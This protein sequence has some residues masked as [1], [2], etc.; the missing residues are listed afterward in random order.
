MSLSDDELD[1]LIG[2]VP[3]PSELGTRSVK[4]FEQIVDR[5]VPR[6]LHFTA[7]DLYDEYVANDDSSMIEESLALLHEALAALTLPLDARNEQKAGIL[8]DIASALLLRFDRHGDPAD[9]LNSIRMNC[10]AIGA[11][12]LYSEVHICILDGFRDAIDRLHELKERTEVDLAVEFFRSPGIIHPDFALDP[13]FVHICGL[14]LYAHFQLLKFLAI[15]DLHG[16]IL[17]FRQAIDGFGKVKVKARKGYLEC[18]RSLGCA[19]L[20]CFDQTGDEDHLKDLLESIMIHRQV[21]AS[22]RNKKGLDEWAL[23]QSTLALSLQRVS[24]P[25]DKPH[26]RHRY[27][28]RPR[29]L[30]LV[31]DDPID[32]AIGLH[33]A[34]RENLPRED[35]NSPE[36]I[37]IH[38]IAVFTKFQLRSNP[39]DLLASTTL[40]K[41]AIGP[42]QVHSIDSTK[43]KELYSRACHYLALAIQE[44][45]PP[46]LEGEIGSTTRKL[47]ESIAYFEIAAIQDNVRLNNLAKALF[48][49]YRLCND[50][51][52]VDKAV[53]AFIEALDDTTEAPRTRLQWAGHWVDFLYNNTAISELMDQDLRDKFLKYCFDAVALLRDVASFDQTIN[54]RLET[55]KASSTLAHRASVLAIALGNARCGIEI[56]EGGR[57]I[58]WS[59]ALRLR[60][61]STDPTMQGV[62]EELRHFMHWD[63]FIPKTR[64]T[65]ESEKLGRRR[66]VAD[67]EADLD[68]RLPM[69]FDTYSQLSKCCKNGAVVILV[70]GLCESYAVLLRHQEEEPEVLTLPKM[71]AV[72]LR[73]RS[74]A[75]DRSDGDDEEIERHGKKRNPAPQGYEAALSTLWHDIVRPIIWRL[76]YKKSDLRNRPRIWWCPSGLF[77][78]LPLHAAGIYSG[79]YQDCLSDHAISSYTTSLSG[80]TRAQ[81]R[82]TR[83][84]ENEKVLVVAEPDPPAFFKLSKIENVVKEVEIIKGL[85][86]EQ[87]FVHI[88]EAPIAHTQP[89]APS[90]RPTV[91]PYL[92][93]VS[94]AFEGNL[95]AHIVHFSCHAKQDQESP[96]FSHFFI[97][98]TRLTVGRLMEMEFPNARFA[99]LSACQTATGDRVQ[100]EESI[101]LASVMSFVGFPS[102]IGTMWPM[103]DGDGP[104]VTEKV[105]RALF[106]NGCL[107][108]NADL[109][110]IALDDAVRQM[111]AQKIPAR[112][113]APY[114]HI[115]G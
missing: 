104:F 110:P 77:T 20:D 59:Q 94:T 53:L 16:C 90:S 25:M 33:V 60:D 9:L 100:S 101:H 28:N 45:L 31:G 58:F 107:D 38:G 35:E 86:P 42:L 64:N 8:D 115:G 3:K 102:I 78:S 29:S 36:Y 67:F 27:R 6:M 32:E 10:E 30:D 109:I 83:P 106:K 19:L 79:N 2:R 73:G 12:I 74:S 48:Y 91:T 81:E 13:V 47:D 72:Y 82:L 46:H 57:A 23:H 51:A 65:E 1:G 75:F 37:L 84:F 63:P 5:G 34:I 69:A 41:E 14:A 89:A 17:L 87:S 4:G 7:L 21:L 49:K 92:S 52:T 54:N 88:S 85:V 39:E 50:H 44:S 24:F 61:A 93:Q 68:E 55:L 56:L 97:M 111:R 103:N 114:I 113:W 99:F 80:L 62:A 40:L 71:D 98:G 105:Y 108:S 66:Q 76:G 22:R 70:Q 15:D 96:L 18:M 112:R 11:V 26:I 43:A 95:D